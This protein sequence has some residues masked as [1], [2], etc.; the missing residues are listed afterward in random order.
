LGR[1]WRQSACSCRSRL[2]PRTR[3]AR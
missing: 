2:P 1:C 3:L